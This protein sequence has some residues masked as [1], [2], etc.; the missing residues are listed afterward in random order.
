MQFDPV[1]RDACLSVNKVKEANA[2][3]ANRDADR[4]EEGRRGQASFELRPG[5]GNS[6]RK[7]TR[8][9]HAAGTRNLGYQSGAVRVLQDYVVVDIILQLVQGQRSCNLIDRVFSGTKPRIDGG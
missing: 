3:N 6:R 1:R 9:R 2:G 5:V 4:L 8:S 7:R